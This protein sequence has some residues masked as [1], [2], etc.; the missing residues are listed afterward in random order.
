MTTNKTNRSRSF[1]A[2]FRDKLKDPQYVRD[3]INATLDSLEE[4]DEEATP[5][6]VLATLI[7]ALRDII[8]ANGGINQFSKKIPELHRSTLYGIFSDKDKRKNGPEF[9]TVLKI[10]KVC[11]VSL[12]AA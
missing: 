12:K 9:L 2:H 11:G 1:D 4:D 8:E 7:G 6:E 5:E 3:Y 10:M